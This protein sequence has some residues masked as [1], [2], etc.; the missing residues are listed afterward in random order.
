MNSID[1]LQA[2]A[3]EVVSCT[4]CKLHMSRKNAVPGE[5]P[6]NAEIIFIGE[7]PGFHE[8]EQGRPF[9]G[10][11]GRFLEELLASVGL[12]RDQVFICNVIKCRPPGNRDPTPE[13][14][15]ACA[16]YLDRQI[17]AISP[18]VIVTLGR[19]SMARYFPNARISSIHG[20]A[21]MV[22]GRWVIPMYH[23]AAALHQPRLREVVQEDFA[24]LPDLVAKAR[25]STRPDEE[26]PA[27]PEQLSLF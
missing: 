26:P 14:I 19:F 24:R 18:V 27:E 20:R 21:R 17:R 7:G 11:A 13:E 25:N 15:Q 16:K 4:D 9:V 3:N 2:V 22:N 12:G 5:G 10:A 1:V 8:N 6:P 23:P